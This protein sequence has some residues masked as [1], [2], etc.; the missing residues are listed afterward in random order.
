MGVGR[1]GKPLRDEQVFEDLPGFLADLPWIDRPR[2]AVPARR[3]VARRVVGGRALTWGALTWGAL[4]WGAVA[5]RTV[6]R[7]TVARRAVFRRAVSGRAARGV[8]AVWR[9][10]GS[11][12]HCK[13]G[14]VRKIWVGL[15]AI[16]SGDDFGRIC[17]DGAP[18]A[19]G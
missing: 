12:W 16:G 19:T 13:G 8:G 3:V 6:A 9:Y 15:R 17:F 10:M 5:G 7:R 11:V 4:A 2:G 18:P 14:S 1:P